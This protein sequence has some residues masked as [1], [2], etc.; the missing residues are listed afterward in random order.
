M[1]M[2]LGLRGVVSLEVLSASANKSRLGGVFM[3]VCDSGVGVLSGATP[4]GWGG[5]TQWSPRRIGGAHCWA[6]LVTRIYHFPVFSLICFPS[7]PSLFSHPSL[8]L[9]VSEGREDPKK[10][11]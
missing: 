10:A 7:L 1:I 11:L 8:G 5:K 2:C 9:E 3:T 6:R 4:L